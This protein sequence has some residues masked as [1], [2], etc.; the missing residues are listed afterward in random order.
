MKKSI[1]ICFIA[2]ITVL[3]TN[4][5]QSK[6]TTISVGAEIGLPSGDLSTGWNT[7]LGASAKAAFSTSLDV[8]ITAS[9]GYIS[10]AGKSILGTSLP[11]WNTIPIK[12]G[13]RYK[14]GGSA[15]NIEPQVGY[16]F[17][18]ISGISSS[19]A[20]GLTWAICAGYFFTSKIDFGIRY[21]SFKT[22]GAN[23]SANLIGLRLGYTF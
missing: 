5:Q 9:A 21:E 16:T 13:V 15:F 4:A 20:S 2:L 8:D 6:N 18:S 7:G 1:S 17:G 22:S 3:S 11:S 12:A 19:N 23:S 14:V 10:Y